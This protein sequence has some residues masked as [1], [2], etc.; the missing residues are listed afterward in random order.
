MLIRAKTEGNLSAIVTWFSDIEKQIT[1]AELCKLNSGF[2][3]Y[4]TGVHPDN[5]DRTNKKSHESWISQTEDLARRPECLGI[6]TGLNLN[7]EFGTHFAQETLLKQSCELA[8][9]LLLPIILHIPDGAS[10]ER[11]IEVLREVGWTHDSDLGIESD[12][13]RRVLIHDIITSCGGNIDRLM[14]A[15]NA[16]CHMV[17]SATGLTDQDPDIKARAISC[18]QAIPL[19][20]LLICSDSPWKT[21]QNLPDLYLRTLRNEPANIPFIVLAISQ[22]LSDSIS[23][24]SLA[25]LVRENSLKVFGLDYVKFEDQ[26]RDYEESPFTLDSENNNLN[27]TSMKNKMKQTMSKRDKEILENVDQIIA[28]ETKSMNKVVETDSIEIITKE[29]YFGCQKCRLKLF[30][31]NDVKNHGIDALKTVFKAGDQGLCKSTIFLSCSDNKE[32]SLRTGIQVRGANAECSE[33]GTKLGKYS[34]AE[35]ACA[36]GAIV[37]GPSVRIQ[38]IKVDFF[39]LTLDTEELV[40]ISKL[41]AEEAYRLASLEEEDKLQNLKK[42][43]KTKKIRSE[44]K[45]NFSNY[46]NKSFRP[47]ASKSIQ[48]ESDDSDGEQSEEEIDDEELKEES[49]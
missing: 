46:R 15:V 14:L 21:P 18:V 30:V 4:V 20:K 5:I 27:E 32:I 31:Q 25:L 1:L 38:S 39:D 22:I 43:K 19:E 24:E 9:K 45:G 3:Y 23:Q 41:E 17:V 42:M 35:S 48:Q 29:S 8:D 7:R 13:S 37:S 2:C 47:N 33:C 49:D 34:N 36:C 11:T 12:G 6:L 28:N 10:L 16:G 26:I 40:A 44:N